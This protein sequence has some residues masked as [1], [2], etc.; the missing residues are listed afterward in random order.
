MR[1][2]ELLNAMEYLNPAYIEAADALPRAKRS[3]WRRWGALAAC[4][5]LVV[6]GAVGLFFPQNTNREALQWREGFPAEDYFKYNPDTGSATAGCFPED[7][8]PHGAVAVQNFSH[9]R[10]KLEAEGM[11]PAMPDYPLYQCTVYYNGDGSIF[12]ISHWWHREGDTYSDLTITIVEQEVKP[13]RDSVGEMVDEAGNVIPPPVTVTERDGIQI[14]AQGNEDRDKTLTF[15]NDRA[16]YQITGS[17]KD[18]CQSVAALL[19]WVWEHPVDFGRFALS[20]F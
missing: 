14:V 9:D 12:S 10:A 1:G 18:S 15:Q 8:M 20:P 13:I 11:I 17:W 4:L 6:A 3:G 16:W 7:F 5:C 19:D 2:H